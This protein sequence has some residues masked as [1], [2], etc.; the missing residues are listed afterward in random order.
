MDSFRQPAAYT[1][2]RPRT[3]ILQ[4][5]TPEEKATYRR[6]ARLVLAGYCLVLIWGGIA[7]LRN[8][9]AANSHDRLAQTSPQRNIP[10]R[11]GR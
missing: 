5:S 9:S 10:T 11:A 1:T 3:A 2:R 4:A 8:H 7:V 6:W